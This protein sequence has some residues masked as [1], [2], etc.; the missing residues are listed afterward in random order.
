METSPRGIDLI[1]LFEGEKLRAYPDPATGGEPWTIGVGHTSAA[2]PPKVTRGML[3]SL[4]NSRRILAR[5]LKK[6]EDGVDAAVT[7]VLTQNQFD[8]IVS[9]AFN[10]GLGNF[11]KSTLLKKINREDFEGAA[12]EFAKWNKAAGKVMQG[13]TNRRA[14]EAAVFRGA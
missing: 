14:A 8:A 10:V 13:L 6:F 7:T 4:G 9:F 5:D 1:I 2:G 12:V 11:R 3:I